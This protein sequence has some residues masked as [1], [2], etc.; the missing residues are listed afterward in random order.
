MTVEIVADAELTALAL[1]CEECDSPDALLARALPHLCRLAGA[2]GAVVLE[3]RGG[4]FVATAQHEAGGL[5]VSALEGHPH[6]GRSATGCAVPAEWADVGIAAVVC[7]PLPGLWGHLVLV[8]PS[9][10]GTPSSSYDVGLALVLRAVEALDTAERLRDLQAR[11]DNAQQL[12]T[13][14]DYDWHI[15]SDTNQWSDQLYRIYGHEPQSFNASYERFLSFIHPDDRTMVTEVHQRA[16]AT[17]EPYQMIERILRPDGELRYLASNG[18]VLMDSDGAPVRFRGT[19]IDITDRIRAEEERERSRVLFGEL[20]EASPDS[21][22]VSGPDGVVVQANGQAAALLGGD[23]V[24]RTLRDIF[25]DAAGARVDGLGV[26]AAGLD[27][28][29]LVLDVRSAPLE[30]RGRDVSAEDGVP[31][32]GRGLVA[33]FLRDARERLEGEA[34]AAHLREAQVRRRQALEINDNVVQGLS[35]ALYALE[36]GDAPVA[37]GLQRRTLAAARQM[38]S[39]LLD[40]LD[41]TDLQPGDLVRSR[42]S[43]VSG[44]DEK[45]PASDPGAEDDLA[46]PDRRPEPETSAAGGS[47]GQRARILVVDDS[48]DVRFLLSMQLAGMAGVE[49]VG[50]AVDGEDAVRRAT[51]LRPDLVL[52]DLAMPRMDG[53]QAL[54][55]IREAVPGVRVVVLSGFEDSVMADRAVEAGASRYVEK[56]TAL[57]QLGEVIDETL[58]LA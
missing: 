3:S 1:A 29:A 38:M 44:P 53:L 27:G 10:H 37:V 31:A 13:M 58:A 12:A 22:V 23:P 39:D 5:D 18:Q 28:S 6:L 52:L 25:G 50:E 11:V 41:G 51:E 55:L 26:A 9:G 36:A 48:E 46:Q 43:T 4:V 34:L 40:P 35:A 33:L 30:E 24:G 20:V 32:S 49:V 14:G 7:Q 47:E 42:A 15:A 8:W 16:Y 56:G 19:C 57:H 17:G 21:I 45:V 2:T 54:P